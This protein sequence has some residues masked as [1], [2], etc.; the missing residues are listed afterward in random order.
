VREVASEIP[1]VLLGSDALPGHCAQCQELNISGHAIKPVRRTDLLRLVFDALTAKNV[2]S[3]VMAGVPMTVPHVAEGGKALR[4][5]IAEDSVDNRLLLNAYLKGS[6]HHLTFVENGKAAV[7]SFL[8]GAF[9]LILMDMQ[10]P[11]MD[12]LDATRAIRA[13]ER[14]EGFARIPIIALTANVH[15]REIEMTR[16]A[17]CD[18]HLSKPVSRQKILETLAKYDTVGAFPVSPVTAK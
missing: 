12:G 14:N 15:L 1:I 9:D 8:T 6:P 11:V 17:G 10:M 16:D 2:S 5:L 7:D 4:I 18:I 3:H 13:L